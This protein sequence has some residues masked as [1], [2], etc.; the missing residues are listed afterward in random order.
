MW[1]LS[2]DNDDDDDDDDDASMADAAGVGDFAR[3]VRGWCEEECD[4]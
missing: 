4:D 2:N 1:C 3:G